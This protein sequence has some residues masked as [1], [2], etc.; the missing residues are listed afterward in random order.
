MNLFI[1]SFVILLVLATSGF[2]VASI[3]KR[4][5]IPTKSNEVKVDEGNIKVPSISEIARKYPRFQSI[6][7]G[8]GPLYQRNY[9]ARIKGAKYS[10]L[11]LMHVI[12]AN[13]NNFSPQ[14]LARFD[15]YK[16]RDLHTMNIGDQYH[17][18]ITGPWDGPVEVVEQSLES[19]T[20]ATRRDHLEAGVIVFSVKSLSKPEELE[21]KITSYARS[22]NELVKFAY[23]DLGV[24]KAAQTNMW[25]FFCNQVVQY[26]GGELIS[27]IEIMTLTSKED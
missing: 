12:Q 6:D 21:F 27:E 13:L 5:A 7:E 11:Q 3:A 14:E 1:V 16:Y 22:A 17:I 18:S 15:K 9:V 10:A 26:S 8:A 4:W 19:F 2:V 23:E 25:A 24:A 20:L